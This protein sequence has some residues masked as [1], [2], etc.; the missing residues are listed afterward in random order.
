MQPVEDHH[1]PL[2]LGEL[3]AALALDVLDGKRVVA[4]RLARGYKPGSAGATSWQRC[5]R[6]R[7]LGAWI[8]L[9]S[10]RC[11]LQPVQVELA[12]GQSLECSVRRQQPAAEDKG[13]KQYTN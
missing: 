7:Q 6:H 5:S 8:R 3:L 2:V 9:R 1:V 4:V 11:C 10:R 13:M 12:L